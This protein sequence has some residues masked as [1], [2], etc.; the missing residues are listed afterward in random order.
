MTVAERHPHFGFKGTRGL[1]GWRNSLLTLISYP[2]IPLSLHSSFKSY[3]FT[4][5]EILISL[6]IIGIIAVITLP[7]LRANINEKAW[8]TQRKALHSRMS[9]ALLLMGNINGYGNYSG[10]Y[11]SG[12]GSVTVTQDTAAETFVTEGLSKVFKINN[13]CD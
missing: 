10:T 13:I 11:N 3:A 6:T 1:E 12:N 4:M 7:S 2:S 9:Q 5:A 8:V